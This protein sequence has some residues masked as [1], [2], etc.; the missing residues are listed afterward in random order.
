MTDGQQ[1]RVNV[2]LTLDAAE[3]MRRLQARTGQSKVDIVCKALQIYDFLDEE[4]RTGSEVW[5]HGDDTQ[6]MVRILR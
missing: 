2:A 5:L 4:L 6:F 1:E 3:S